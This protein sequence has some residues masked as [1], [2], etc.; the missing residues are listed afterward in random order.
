MRS[1]ILFD[2]LDRKIINLVLKNKYAIL[3]LARKLNIKHSNLKKHL[4]RLR[5]NDL[6]K[7]TDEINRKQISLTEKGRRFYY[8]FEGWLK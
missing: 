7:I 5:N 6:I 3:E 4:D 2:E 8:L 1:R